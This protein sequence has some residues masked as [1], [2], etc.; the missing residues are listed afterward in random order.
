LRYT[1]EGGC[2]D[3]AVEK[4]AGDVLV[5]VSDNGPGVPAEDLPNI[6]Q[7]FWRGEKSRSRISGGAGLGLAIAQQLVEAQGGQ[8]RA[9]NRAQGGLQI[10]IQ[11]PALA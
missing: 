10:S 11:F 4:A 6:F 2:V 1:P 5:T 7:R 3:L 8:I 9:K